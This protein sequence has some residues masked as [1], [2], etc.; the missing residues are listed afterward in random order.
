VTALSVRVIRTRLR[1]SAWGNVERRPARTLGMDYRLWMIA[2]VMDRA[3]L[4]GP[5][6]PGPKGFELSLSNDDYRGAR[7]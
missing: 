7:R 2:S 5:T 1:V 6:F 4:P 3:A